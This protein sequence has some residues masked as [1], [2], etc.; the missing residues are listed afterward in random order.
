MTVDRDGRLYVT[1]RMGLQVCDPP[2]RVHLI[3]P[4]PHDAWLSNVTFG[5]P[6]MDTLYVTCGD[7]VYRRRVNAHGVVPWQAAIKPPKPR[8]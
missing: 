1:T 6:E 8:L 3:L 7:R 5:G 4:K 2:G